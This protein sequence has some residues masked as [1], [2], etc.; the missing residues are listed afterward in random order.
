[1]NEETIPVDANT[2]H[3]LV[4]GAVRYYL[5]R[6]TIAVWGVC[7]DL[8]AMLPQLEERTKECM[9][10]DISRWLDGRSEFC[11]GAV[12]DHAE[13]WRDLLEALRKEEKA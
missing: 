3:L 2:L 4:N 6:S 10:R 11:G 8:T 12:I 1:M 13:L 5:G 7:R 9:E